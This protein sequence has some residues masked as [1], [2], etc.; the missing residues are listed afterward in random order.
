MAAAPAALLLLWEDRHDHA[1]IDTDLL[2]KKMS[3][4]II[5][6]M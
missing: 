3:E 5:K 4:K 6:R 2:D 1:Y